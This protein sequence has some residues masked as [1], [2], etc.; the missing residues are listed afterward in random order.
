MYNIVTKCDLD[1]KNVE[2]HWK[3]CLATQLKI[4]AKQQWKNLISL[5][6][7]VFLSPAGQDFFNIFF[8]VAE[9]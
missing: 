6:T 9:I 8:R 4:A 2:G 5:T 7:C 3:N 1:G